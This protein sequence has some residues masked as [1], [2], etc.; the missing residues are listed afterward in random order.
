MSFISMHAAVEL[1]RRIM[2]VSVQ[3]LRR[4]EFETGGMRGIRSLEGTF[5]G[6]G[7]E[8]R[9]GIF[10][11]KYLSG[12]ISNGLGEHKYQAT[13]LTI[14]LSLTKFHFDL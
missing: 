2:P 13:A 7:R 11:R 3:M 8:H 1:M 4:S 14:P 10:R 5:K 6:A 9:I 12:E